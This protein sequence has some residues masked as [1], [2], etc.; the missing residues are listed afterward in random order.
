MDDGHAQ[1][2]FKSL[3]AALLVGENNTRPGLDRR[4][5]E[6][7]AVLL[8]TRDCDEQPLGLA[9]VGRHGDAAQ[10]EGGVGNL[11]KRTVG[12]VEPLDVQAFEGGRQRDR[13]DRG[14]NISH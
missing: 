13:R 14:T 10:T 12:S 6:T 3:G 2:A 1:T 9:V 4:M 5:R 8:Q 11:G 7:D